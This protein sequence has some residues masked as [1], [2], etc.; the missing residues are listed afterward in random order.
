MTVLITGGMGF[1]GLSTVEAFLNAGDEVVATYRQTWR[2]P[3]FLEPYMGKRLT[4]E[5]VDLD[6]HNALLDVARKHKVDGIVHMAIHTRAYDHPGDD[7][8]ANMD[9][10][11]WLLDAAR[12]AGVRRLSLASNSAPYADLPEG[13]YR[14]D[15][16]LPIDTN[17]APAAFK[18]AWEILTLQ[19]ARASGLDIV[20]MRL[21]GVYGPMYA[22]MRNL[23]SRLV[24]A[25]VKGTEPDFS[26]AF[27]GTP[28]ADDA[29]D[30]TYVKDIARGVVLVHNAPKLEHRIY[31]I[32]SGRA[33]SNAEIL[34][35]VRKAK[36]GF[37]AH[38]SEGRSPRY[39][40]NN[41]GDNTRIQN[42]L[43]YRPQYD[44]EKAIADYVAW[45][46]AGNPQ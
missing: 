20:N 42:E 39:K 11:S 6:D 9:K 14:E 40:P 41:Y 23:P 16:P 5:Q 31:N 37:D 13:P 10:L 27:G 24:H 18:K 4:Y 22:S 7:L 34:A 3:S 36:P 26:P 33:T 29:Q 15:D 17:V 1:I 38:L 2:L 25:A 19:Y 21:S 46:E 12:D 28:H 45:L 30:L 35:A 8:R 43:G 44:L 32:G